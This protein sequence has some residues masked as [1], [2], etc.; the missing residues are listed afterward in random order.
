MVLKLKEPCDLRGTSTSDEEKRELVR[1]SAV[2]D[3][4]L[5][6]NV[7]PCPWLENLSLAC[8]VSQ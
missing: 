5:Y 4:L 3:G 1:M 7:L 8:A 2:L 6:T